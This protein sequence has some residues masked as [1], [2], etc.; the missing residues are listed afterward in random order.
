[1]RKEGDEKEM[2]KI[3]SV[4]TIRGCASE[5]ESEATNPWGNGI[6]IPLF[7]GRFDTG[8]RVEEFYVWP[9][10]FSGNSQPDV[11]GKLTSSGE[12]SAA[13]SVFFNAADNREIAWSAGL[14]QTDGNTGVMGQAVI[15]PENMTVEDLFF[16][17]R[18]ATDTAQVN[19]L[20][21]LQKYD[22]SEWEGSLIMARDHQRGD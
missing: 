9:Q 12:C 22:I 21:V 18:G 17:A 5:N 8:Y 1:M 14:G 13:P 10:N 20:A 19:Y 2:K 16:F 11:L 4:Y 15:D 7:D 3:G 6:R